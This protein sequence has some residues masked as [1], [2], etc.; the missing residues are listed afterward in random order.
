[1]GRKYACIFLAA[2]VSLGLLYYIS[3]Y[4]HA[5]KLRKADKQSRDYT[6]GEESWI[7]DYNIRGLLVEK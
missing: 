5:S 3:D 7:R 2:F 1:M 6:C 4:V